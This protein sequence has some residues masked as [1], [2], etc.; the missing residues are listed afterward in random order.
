[1]DFQDARM[2]NRDRLLR[3]ILTGLNMP[4]PNPCTLD[5]FMDVVSHYLKAPAV[6]LMDEIGA[7]LAFSELD[8]TFWWALRSLVSNFAGGSLAFV[9]TSHDA[10][11]RLAQDLGKPS[12]FFNI[13]H[14][15]EL[16]PFTDKEACELISSSPEPFSPTDVGWILE[17]SRRW[18][19]LLQVLCR[20]R[21]F[22]LQEGLSG[23]AWRQTALQQT[24]PFRHL[25]GQ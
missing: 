9:L 16:G 11:A 10:P 17:Q 25:L 2:G 8:Q 6:V 15:L 12:P 13:F 21:L 23:D 19:C 18:P 20:E 1:V 14:V 3:H 24:A 7:G 5:A 4:V 22:A